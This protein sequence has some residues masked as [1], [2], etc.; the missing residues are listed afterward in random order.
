MSVLEYYLSMS[1]FWD[2]FTFSRNE[3]VERE[4][5]KTDIKVYYYCLLYLK[6]IDKKRSKNVMQK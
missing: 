4:Y 6:M 2:W 3:L 1:S 5:L